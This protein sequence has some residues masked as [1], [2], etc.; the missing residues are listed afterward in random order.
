MTTKFEI[1]NSHTSIFH[2]GPIQDHEFVALN[3]GQTQNSPFQ[4]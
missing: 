2:H 4:E 3:V 1:T